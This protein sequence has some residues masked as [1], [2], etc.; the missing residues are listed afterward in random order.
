[1]GKPWTNEALLYEM[2]VEERM[3]QLEIA[4]KLGCGDSTISNWLREY[5]IKRPWRDESIMRELYEDRMMSHPQIAE[6]LDCGVPTVE[7]W[8]SKHGIE[9]RDTGTAVSVE[10]FG[11]ETYQKLHDEQYLRELY[12]ERR[13]SSPEIAEKIGCSEPALSVR[14]SEYGIEMRDRSTR[15]SLGAVSQETHEALRDADLMEKLYV[16]QEMSLHDLADELDCSFSTVRTWLNNHEIPL[17]TWAE[18]ALSG[19]D[20]P[21]WKENT[22]YYGP[23]WDEQRTKR[24][25]RD[26]RECVVC[27]MT[28]AEHIKWTGDALHVHH[29]RPRS[30]FIDED[31]TYDYERGN[32]LN[33]LVT[34]CATCHRK[35]EGVPLRPQ[36]PT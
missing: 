2:Y 1:M 28:M 6:E 9:G 34:L 31:G 22:D 24:R 21:W 23:N 32:R 36:K 3:S 26:D 10:A 5:D 16:E 15:T 12:H 18:A 25:E 8:M 4:E 19:E 27:T 17:R 30:E 7:E 35:W 11:K 33:N 29:I 14:F 13:L 20:H